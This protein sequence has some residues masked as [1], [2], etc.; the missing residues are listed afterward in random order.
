MKP[1][2]LILMIC[3]G[4]NINAQSRK[5]LFD[6]LVYVNEQWKN[7]PDAEASLKTKIVKSMT[8]VDAIQFHLEQTE[9]LLRNRNVSNLPE[10]LQQQRLK[11]LN[12]LH[13]Y[14]KTG[15]FPINDKHQN[16]QPYF[17]DKNN[18]YCA[19][20]YLMK[21]SGANDIAKEIS[22]NQN[23]DYLLNIQHPKLMEWIEN[24]G[25]SIN[26]LALI[27]PGYGG[28]WP[29]AI[30]ELHYNNAGTDVNEY[31]E[32]HQSS[33]LLGG[34]P[35]FTAIKFYNSSSILYKTLLATDMTSIGS[36]QGSVRFYS[37]PSGEDFSDIG[38]IE[39]YAN[40]Q[41]LSRYTYNETS[42][43][44]QDYYH[45]PPA[46]RT[47]NIGESESTPIGNALTFCG[48]YYNNPTWT[49]QSMGA[50]TG[51]INACTI[52]PLN[53]TNF[54]AGVLGKAVKLSWEVSTA[55]KASY[56]IVEKSSNGRNFN[57]LGKVE[58][59]TGLQNY[60][61]S[62]KAP[63]YTNHYRLKQ[64]D[65]DGQSFYSKII[66]VKVESLN[67]LIVT[68]NLV[69]DILK[70]TINTGQGKI[71]TLLVYDMYGRKVKTFT[72]KQ[73]YQQLN[74]STIAPGKYYLQ[75][76]TTEGE[77]YYQAFVK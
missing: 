10:N 61:L 49:L 74:I 39:L 63:F 70:V 46:V 59:V 66:F 41:L 14:W 11:N 35:Y 62:D 45:N 58:A 6:V 25:L 31:I 29:S 67:A 32:V 4:L 50:T 34:A 73:G 13:S 52:M 54:T 28:E 40:A 18:T 33:L 2:L 76:V 8:E 9:K 30:M 68:E 57:F 77:V 19:V 60:S 3:A 69:K 5:S 20:G 47:F 22:K 17:I 37:F 55:S 75:L 65:K 16:R 53:L 27:Q 44:L 1:L 38:S 12:V 43:V 36:G 23:Y 56:Y 48:F 71:K 64:V 24:S 26:E 51:S 42:V 72:A 15:V 7:Q 21:E